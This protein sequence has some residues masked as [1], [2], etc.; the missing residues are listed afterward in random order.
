MSRC[1]MRRWRARKWDDDGRMWNDDLNRLWLLL[2]CFWLPKTLPLARRVS[3]SVRSGDPN[4]MPAS[5][6]VPWVAGCWTGTTGTPFAPSPLLGEF[7]PPTVAFSLVWVLA[8]VHRR[9]KSRARA[10]D[11]EIGGKGRTANKHTRSRHRDVVIGPPS[12][13]KGLTG[14]LATRALAAGGVELQVCRCLR[15][16]APTLG[17]DYGGLT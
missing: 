4:S 2:W 1:G 11:G 8:K 14:K 12:A 9:G 16:E 5:C 7:Y 15:R 3:F 6:R 17:E 10:G 13:A